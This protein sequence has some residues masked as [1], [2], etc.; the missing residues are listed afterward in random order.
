MM[1]LYLENKK[2]RD[3]DWDEILAF[4]ASQSI[5]ASGVD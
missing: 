4:T 2:Y 1:Q 5:L 3:S